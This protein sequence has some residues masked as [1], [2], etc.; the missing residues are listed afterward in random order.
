MPTTAPAATATLRAV[1]SLRAARAAR[2]LERGGS[3]CGPTAG[4][5]RAGRRPI[6][7]AACSRPSGTGAA[8]SL[9]VH[10]RDLAG[11]AR[12]RRALGALAGRGLRHPG[13]AGGVERQRPQRSRPARPGRQRAPAGRRR[14]ADARRRCSR[15]CPS[16]PRGWPRRRPRSAP[17][18]SSPRPAT[19]PPA[20]RP[21][22][23]APT[24]ARRSRGPRSARPRGRAAAARPPP[25]VAP[26]TVRL[27][28]TP[29]A[30][31]ASKARSST[32]RP[33]RSSARPDEQQPQL[34]VAVVVGGRAEARSTPL[35]IT[36]VLPAVE[37]LRRPARRLRD[38][39]PRVELRVQ[40][41]G[42]GS[43]L[44]AN[45]LARGIRG[46]GVEGADHRRRAGLGGEPAR[47][48]PV[49][50]VHVDH[51]VAA[52]AKLLAQRADRPR[53]DA[54]VRHR[55]VHRQTDRAAERDTK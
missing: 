23:A 35:G 47:R 24:C 7:A 45:R 36:A 48:G 43:T 25:P 31:R 33:L 5:G 1:R 11:H 46:V 52:V 49:G 6:R 15:R 50:L 14:R 30:R 27:A 2:R 38:G 41:G 12:P 13:A 9:L 17:S 19:A 34:V 39:D 42:P 29:A 32:G 51:V 55:A 22:P 18:R 4:P 20:G 21:R 44:A 16:T 53:E 3:R 54:D 8:A 40:R 10:L 28:G 37:A 26:A